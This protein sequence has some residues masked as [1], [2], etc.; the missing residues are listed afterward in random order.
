[1]HGQSR[2]RQSEI[3]DSRPASCILLPCTFR[4]DAMSWEGRAT[5]GARGER[6]GRWH[7]DHPS[8]R[9]VTGQALE[10]KEQ[11]IAQLT[12]TADELSIGLPA[13]SRLM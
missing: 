10:T 4:W 6:H 8:S 9:P 3:L 1:M 12:Q 13:P 11:T 7:G 2:T 5:Y